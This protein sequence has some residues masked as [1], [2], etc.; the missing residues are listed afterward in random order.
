MEYASLREKIA[1]EKVERVARYAKFEAAYAKAYAAG[2]AA[3]KA[4]VP[5][6]MVVS[7]AEGLS[8]R[9]KPG[10]KSWYVSEGACGFAWVSVHPGN[11]SFAKWLKKAGHA[12]KHY[13]GGVSIWIGEHNQSIARKEAHA[14][15]MAKVLREE[16]NIKAYAGSRLD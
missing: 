8:N 12:D 4:A 5:E 15:A 11:S 14:Y 7:E 3:G 10:G 2:M 9:P 6:P 16:L 13:G 1:A